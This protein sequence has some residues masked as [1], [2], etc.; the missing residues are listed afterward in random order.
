MKRDRNKS[1][2]QKHV[3]VRTYDDDNEFIDIPI[4]MYKKFCLLFLKQKKNLKFVFFL[5]KKKITKKKSHNMRR[6][7]K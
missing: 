7:S 6:E 1:E 5:F 4:C 2:T 3:T